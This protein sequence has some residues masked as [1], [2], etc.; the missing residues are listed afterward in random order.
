MDNLLSLSTFIPR[1]VGYSL[2]ATAR[3]HRAAGLH[4]CGDLI[5]AGARLLCAIPGYT[6]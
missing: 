3:S 2:E 6:H 5:P 4:K 1:L